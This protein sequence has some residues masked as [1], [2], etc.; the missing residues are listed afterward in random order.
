[1]LRSV[2]IKSYIKELA[3]IRRAVGKAGFISGSII[4]RAF[5]RVDYSLVI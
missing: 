3:I 2:I 4:L 5:V 1:M